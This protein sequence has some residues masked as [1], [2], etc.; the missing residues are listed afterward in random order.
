M[1]CPGQDSRYWK[2]G[3]IFG[4]KCPECGGEVEFFKDDTRPGDAKAADTGS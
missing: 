1:K 3:A 4:A 2:P